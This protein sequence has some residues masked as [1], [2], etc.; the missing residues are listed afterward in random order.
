MSPSGFSNYA[1]PDP[2]DGGLYTGM[3]PSPVHTRSDRA[4]SGPVRSK[5]STWTGFWTGRSNPVH[6]SSHMIKNPQ[7]LVKNHDYIGEI[8]DILTINFIRKL[9]YLVF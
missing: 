2:V 1:G 4:R 5:M 6:F 3:G 7:F 8:Q 9:F